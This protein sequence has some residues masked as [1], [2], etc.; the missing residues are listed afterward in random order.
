MDNTDA[1]LIAG[2]DGTLLEVS[3]QMWSLLLGF[4]ILQKF[5]Q[6]P[7]FFITGSYWIMQ[8]RGCS[9]ELTIIFLK[10]EIQYSA[11]LAIRIHQDVLREKNFEKAL[12]IANKN[13]NY[14]IFN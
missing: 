4:Y 6:K 2:G 1:V 11:F 10:T 14:N 9:K 5:I 3:T 12:L 7:R 13:I 8:A